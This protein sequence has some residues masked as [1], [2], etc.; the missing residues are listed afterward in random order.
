MQN[1]AQSK[2]V[3]TA[4][5]KFSKHLADIQ[6][7]MLSVRRT[8]AEEQNKTKLAAIRKRMEKI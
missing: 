5:D 6:D 1:D 2:T 7:R 3:K 4:W 8:A